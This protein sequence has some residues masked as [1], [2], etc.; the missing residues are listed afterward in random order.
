[1]SAATEEGH[2]TRHAE[3]RGGKGVVGYVKTTISTILLLAVLAGAGFVALSLV[4]G[5]WMVTPVLSGSMRPGF[6]VGGVVVSQRVPLNDIAVRDVIVFQNP[7]KP[8]EQMIHRIIKLTRLPS[9]AIKIKTQGDA[10]PVPDPWTVKITTR[11]VYRIRWSVPLVGYVAIAYQNH[12]GILLAV[13]GLLLLLVAA[14][15]WR[16]SGSKK[17]DTAPDDT[18]VPGPADT[19]DPESAEAGE[20]R[21]VQMLTDDDPS[22]REG[23]EHLVQV[24]GGAP[25]SAS[26][27]AT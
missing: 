22:T 27:D 6:S 19:P 3:R 7:I 2:A 18:P 13:A 9:G 20:V 24:A 14:G 5:T 11:F 12:R 17:E 16:K 15:T 21:P 23:T 4:R 10:N 26:R 8:T 1:M 25:S